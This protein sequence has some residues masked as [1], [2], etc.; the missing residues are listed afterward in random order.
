[1]SVELLEVGIGLADAD[2]DNW[3]PRDVD[4]GHGGAHLVV[5]GVELGEHDSINQARL[6]C[7]VR[8]GSV[9]LGD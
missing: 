9:R 7:A 3:L 5:D 1:M 6:P 8:F 4:H 2:E